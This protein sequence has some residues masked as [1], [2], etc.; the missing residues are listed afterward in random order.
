M[1]VI[2]YGDYERIDNTLQLSLWNNS[3]YL[4]VLAI[5]ALTVLF[6]ARKLAN[7]FRQAEPQKAFFFCE[8]L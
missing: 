8:A 4:F 2:L 5:G 1:W 3:V 6:T 7:K